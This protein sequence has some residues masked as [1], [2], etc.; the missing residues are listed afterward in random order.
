[1]TDTALLIRREVS[2]SELAQRFIWTRDKIDGWRILSAPTGPLYGD[3]DDFAVT[4]LWMVEGRSLWRFWWALL[5]FRAV[6]W[7]V[8]GKSFA[9]HVVLW[10]RKHG[11]I[12]NQN[13]TWGPNRDTLRYPVPLPLAILKMLI[14]SLTARR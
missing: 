2:A 4:A 1:M 9:S 5:T 10:H 8:K 14:G 12:D 6:I 13:P 11:W 7:V 3:C